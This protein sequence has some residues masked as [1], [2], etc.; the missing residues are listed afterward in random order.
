MAA[1]KFAEALDLLEKDAAPSG[2][3]GTT[4]TLLK[5]EAAAGAGHDDQAYATSPRAPLPDTRVE[6]ALMKY[7]ADS[8]QDA[9]RRRCRCL[10]H[11]RCEGDRGGAV[12]TAELAGGAPVQLSDFR[13]RLVVLA[14]GFPTLTGCREEFP[15]LQAVLDKYK[16]RGFEV[17]AINVEPTQKNSGGRC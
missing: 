7:A 9:P 12:S 1:S 6:T 15:H 5:A 16:N 14:S 4:L 17:L 13:G 10:A 2:N 8:R 3:H 11:S